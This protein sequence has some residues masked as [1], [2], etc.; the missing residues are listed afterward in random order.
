MA[1]DIGIFFYIKKIEE[2]F[3]WKRTNFKLFFKLHKCHKSLISIT[4]FKCYYSMFSN[5]PRI[6]MVFLI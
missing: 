3:F 2:L 4:I 1:K 6:Q 5:Y